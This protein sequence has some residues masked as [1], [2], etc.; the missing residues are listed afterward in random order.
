MSISSERRGGALKWLKLNLRQ[1]KNLSSKENQQYTKKQ[2]K[3]LI[4][5]LRVARPKGIL[6]FLLKIL[7]W[8]LH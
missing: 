3:R 7:V 5:S 8:G 2:N 1:F 6:P 4:L